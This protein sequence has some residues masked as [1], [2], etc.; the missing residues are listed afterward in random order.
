MKIPAFLK[1]LGVMGLLTAAPAWSVPIDVVGSIDQ[2]IAQTNLDNSGDT[3]E[4]AWVASVLNLELDDLVYEEKTN[5]S[6]ANWELVTGTFPGVWA[7]ELS[8]PVDWFLIKT[9]NIGGGQENRHFLFDNLGSLDY[10]VVRLL[11]MGITSVSNISK[12]SHVGEFNGPNIQVPEPGSLALFGI[13]LL[14]LGLARRKAK[15][16]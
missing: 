15:R 3:T 5:V 4:R 1:V 13:G 11:D 8:G 9:G 7:F 16:V 6:G 12:I 2:L 10:A 14:G